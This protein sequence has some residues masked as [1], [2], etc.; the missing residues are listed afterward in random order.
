I[1]RTLAGFMV[2]SKSEVIIANMLFERDIPFRYE[3][4]RS[5][6]DGTFYLPDFTVTW[7]GRT[8]F[9]EHW[10][11]MED[12]KYRRHQQTKKQWYEKHFPGTLVETFES[13]NLSADADALIK[14]TSH[15]LGGRAISGRAG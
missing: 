3:L 9:W 7:A 12:E 5:A 1:H 10:G 14:G 15:E 6:P 13:T 11:L 2:R 8:W 4:R